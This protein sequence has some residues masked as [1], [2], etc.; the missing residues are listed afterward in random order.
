MQES[1]GRFTSSFSSSCG[2]P[3]MAVIHILL[4]T[5]GKPF[6]LPNVS[7]TLRGNK[8]WADGVAA[9]APGS[10]GSCLG[11]RL[12]ALVYWPERRRLGIKNA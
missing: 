6:S 1:S 9:N 11:R 12:E 5:R 8:L 7:N 10:E 3:R 2:R 4:N